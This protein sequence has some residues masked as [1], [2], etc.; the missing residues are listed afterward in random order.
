M[1]ERWPLDTAGLDAS[2]VAIKLLREIRPDLYLK[3]PRATLEELASGKTLKRL[4]DEL[5]AAREKL[6]E[7]SCPCCG[8]PLIL[9]TDA[10]ADP[11]E[12]YW[13]LRESFECG[14][15]QFGSSMERPCPADSKF[16]KFKDFALH[17]SEGPDSIHQK[18]T[19]H[20]VGKTPMAK[21]LWLGHASGQTKKEA[22]QNLYNQY[23][24]HA[25]RNK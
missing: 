24:R 5:E 13:D 22:K 10:P 20:A 7:Y 17:F 15:T 23:L 2:T 19:C 3:H 6:E 12:K 8:A 16:P 1:S 14:Y 18:W 11:E 4:Q 25:K 9:R 21:K